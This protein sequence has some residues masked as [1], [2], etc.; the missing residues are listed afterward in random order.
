MPK[1]GKQSKARLRAGTSETDP[2]RETTIK[3][4]KNGKIAQER[5]DDC[6]RKCF[7]VSLVPVAKKRAN[8]G[9][10]PRENST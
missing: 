6:E 8:D 9:W 5:E 2:C 7:P 1:T 10:P 3:K 4:D